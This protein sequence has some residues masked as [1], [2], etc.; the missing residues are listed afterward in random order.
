[1]PSSRNKSLA[2]SLGLAAAALALLDVEGFFLPQRG[3]GR[4]A[5]AAVSRASAAGTGGQSPRGS[6]R[7][8]GQTGWA[9]LAGTAAWAACSALACRRR[10]MRAAAKKA[11]DATEETAVYEAGK[12]ALMLFED[13]GKYYTVKLVKD[14]GDGTWAV[15]W[16]EDDAEDTASVEN[17]KPQTKAFEPGDI[18]VAKCADDG[19]RY[20]A[21]VK[22][23]PG[24]G[25]VDVEWLEDG[26]E[27]TVSLDDMFAQKKKFKE[28]QA[29]EAVFP[30]DEQWYG[31]KVLK[32]LEGCM[33]SI[34]WDEVE[35]GQEKIVDMFIDK[36]RVPRFGLDTLEI[37]QKLTG[38]VGNVREFGAFVDV[39]CYT[40][41]LIHVSKMDTKRVTN[42]E[43]YC[44]EEQE[45][46]VWV[47]SIDQEQNRLGL[48]L[49]ES[50]ARGGGKGKGRGKGK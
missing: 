32:V 44:Q 9:G 49:V 41:G 25:Y 10:M 37:G 43:E 24:A 35:E 11:V 16:I 3:V 23:N 31:A 39:G 26:G 18:V 36:I 5:S 50:K 12:L 22:K 6:A 29:I 21:K 1:M 20:T 14:N 4:S 8:A 27:E 38:T 28:G 13:D 15:T 48:T 19:K 46:T 2:P 42:P 33:F 40:D 17:L 34:E 7:M 45:V 30:D 47:C